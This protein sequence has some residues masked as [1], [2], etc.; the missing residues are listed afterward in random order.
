MS[1]DL[2][3]PSRRFGRCEISV[4]PLI[5]RI[6]ADHRL[7]ASVVERASSL[8]A[9]VALLDPAAAVADCTDGRLYPGLPVDEARPSLAT[10][11]D[12]RLLR[13]LPADGARPS[14]ATSWKGRLL[15]GMTV[16]ETQARV[17]TRVIGWLDR[18]GPRVVGLVLQ[19]VSTGQIKAGRAVDRLSRLR[20]DRGLPLWCIEAPDNVLD[21][22]WLIE[23]TPTHGVILRYDASDQSAAYRALQS[24]S[25]LGVAVIAAP[26][27]SPT[28]SAMEAVRFLTGETRVT[29]I[30]LPLPESSEAL[31]EL[32][33]AIFRPMSDEQRASLWR[34]YRDAHPEP[35]RP[36]QGHAIDE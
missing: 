23:N 18:L 22:E 26:V 35:K 21:A 29:S 27:V 24:A 1:A 31:D 34:S 12:D 7:D 11:A 4:P 2:A 25:D 17:A 8:G 20:R 9:D 5:W 30:L 15:L 6:T 13:D 33:A 3:V 28:Q 36:R 16:E 32:L 14:L 10:T 19:G